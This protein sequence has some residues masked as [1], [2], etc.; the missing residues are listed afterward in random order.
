VDDVRYQFEYEK[1]LRCCFIGAGGHSFRNIYPSFQYAPIDLVAV[2]DLDSRRAANYAKLFG[3]G[4]CYTDYRTM[5]TET[6]PDGVFIVTGYDA[7]GRPLA[8]DLALHAL[9]EGCHVW[10]EKPTA[11]SVAEVRQLQEAA[12]K[13]DRVVVT[14]L[15]KMFTPAITKVKEIVSSPDFGTPNAITVRY[16]QALPPPDER[17]DGQA[18]KGFL[19]HIYHPAAVLRYLMGPIQRMYYE[20]SPPSGASITNL[21]F[22]SGAIG[23]L[24]LAAGSAEGAPLEHV[25]VVG[26]GAHIVMDNNVN[27]TYYRRGNHLQYGRSA[28]FLGD[29]ATAPL[30]WSPEL[31]LGQLYNK[32]IFFLG[33]V[34]EILHFCEC[35]LNNRQPERGS[36]DDSLAI[37]QL[38]E[39]YKY[40]DAGQS[41][42]LG[43]LPTIAD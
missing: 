33:Y 38:F 43:S 1:R 23:A 24:H 18:M 28:S 27:V 13:N 11:A 19:D 30:H 7:L 22:S 3:A 41:I 29:E 5:I 17:T 2:C 9:S 21:R 31:S 42:E 4:T 26:Q 10:M 20:W 12:R 15:K 25:E 14:G 6:R 35:V 16:P 36:L 8:T 32:N 39:A 37:V 34:P 40:H